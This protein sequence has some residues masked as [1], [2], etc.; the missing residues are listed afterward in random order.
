M[1]KAEDSNTISSNIQLF[2]QAVGLSNIN[3]IIIEKDGSNLHRIDRSFRRMLY[4]DYDYRVEFRLLFEK[5]KT[6]CIIPVEDEFHFSYFFMRIP[7]NCC[8][9]QSA[10]LSYELLSIG[11]FTQQ[12]YTA[13]LI[14]EI[15]KKNQIPS[16]LL[17]EITAF[18]DSIPV[19]ST[20]LALECLVQCLASGLFYQTY[21][22]VHLPEYDTVFLN[23]HHRKECITEEPMQAIKSME[24][25]YKMENKLLDAIIAGDY[26]RARAMYIKFTTF[27]ISPRTDD[28]VRNQR[29]MTTILNTLLRKAV[30]KAGVPPLYIDDLST[31]FAILI[32]QIDSFSAHRNLEREMIHKYC[33][34]VKN[35]A[36]HGYS[37]TTKNIV[38]YIDF[39]YTENLSLHFFADRYNIT[40]NY[41]SSLFKKET[42]VTL[43]DYIHQ[44]RMRNAMVMINSSDSSVTDVAHSCGYNDIN[45]FTRIFKRIYGLSPKQYKKSILHP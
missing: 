26:D 42:G 34:L 32:N 10:S 18:Y 35:Y 1:P 3:V 39:H 5:I 38:Y 2:Q 9:T 33:L 40:K 7:A 11:P 45:Y 27:K 24:E 19:V 23:N 22:V 4:K 20:P 6:G 8:N 14:M 29:H 36:M 28:P 21:H 37:D 25:R 13:P 17:A 41:L 16:L 44:V 12:C 15:L 43:T 31:K 30:E